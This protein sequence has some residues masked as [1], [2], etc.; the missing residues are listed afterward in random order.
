MMSLGHYEFRQM[1]K[2]TAEKFGVTVI[3]VSEHHTSQT[4]SLCCE[5]N[6]KLGG[7]EVY[8]YTL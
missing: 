8:V 4:C 2:H 1:L 5:R 7:M 3:E 6:L